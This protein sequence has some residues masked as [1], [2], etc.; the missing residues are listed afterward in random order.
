MAISIL[1]ETSGCPCGNRL[2]DFLPLLQKK[3]EYFKIIYM[4][5]KLAQSTPSCSLVGRK[6]CFLAFE[7]EKEGKLRAK[8]K[9]SKK[10]SRYETSV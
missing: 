9:S 10:H 8:I 4:N 7:N 6:L 5:T 2:F 3:S 1:K